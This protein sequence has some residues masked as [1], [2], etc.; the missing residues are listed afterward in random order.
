[1]KLKISFDGKQNELEAENCS[2][3]YLANF[4]YIQGNT[5]FIAE[6]DYMREV[7]LRKPIKKFKIELVEEQK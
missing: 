5:L 2:H 3:S 6:G 1:M 4:L 7:D